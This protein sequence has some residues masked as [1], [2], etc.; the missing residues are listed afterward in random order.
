MATEQL[1]G[2][3]TIRIAAPGWNALSHRNRTTAVSGA[4]NLST[5]GSPIYR[6]RWRNSRESML[7]DPRDPNPRNQPEREQPFGLRSRALLGS[8][9]EAENPKARCDETES[10]DSAQAR[11]VRLQLDPI[12]MLP[13]AHP[14]A[15]TFELV[16]GNQYGTPG[17]L[18]GASVRPILHEA[19]E[20]RARK[21]RREVAR[22]ARSALEDRDPVVHGRWPTSNCRS[23]P[24]RQRI[25]ATLRRIPMIEMVQNAMT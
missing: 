13:G 21:F 5:G 8:E 11:D 14:L 3:A 25:A 20:P 2:A 22:C 10:E 6:A 1:D 24:S 17:R 7:L 4:K 12:R 19:A 18:L 9:Q 15:S 23:D 16:A